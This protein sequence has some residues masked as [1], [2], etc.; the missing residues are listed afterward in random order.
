MSEEYIEDMAREYNKV[1]KEVD[2]DKVSG[3]IAGAKLQP[4]QSDLSRRIRDARGETLI[5][6]AIDIIEL[7][8]AYIDSLLAQNPSRI[9]YKLASY[10][11]SL[12]F[13]SLRRLNALLSQNTF[14]PSH[15]R[16]ICGCT[17]TQIINT[18]LSLQIDLFQVLDTIALS[19]DIQEVLALECRAM[20]IIAAL[21]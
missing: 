4:V 7:Q 8:L 10:L 2:F 5:K 6:N 19:T 3:A 11:R 9:R 17:Q 21:T 1:L 14:V 12:K 18:L 13:A 20:S 15:S 16:P